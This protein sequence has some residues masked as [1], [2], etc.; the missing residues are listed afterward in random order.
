[1]VRRTRSFVAIGSSV[2]STERA[3]PR[4][5]ERARRSSLASL[6]IVACLL[7]ACGAPSRAATPRGSEHEPGI[8]EFVVSPSALETCRNGLDDNQ[9][10]LIDE[11]CSEG[12]ASVLEFVLAWPDAEVDMNLWVIDA[13]GDVVDVGNVSELGLTKQNDCP[14]ESA[15]QAQ[16]YERVFLDRNASKKFTEVRVVVEVVGRLPEGRDYPFFLGVRDGGGT[17]SFS[18][19]LRPGK[20]RV[21]REFSVDVRV[22]EPERPEPKVAA[23][24]P[25][26][27]VAED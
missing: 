16:N 27:A 2:G 1:M 6:G 10:D 4:N 24:E 12:P 14:S 15:C 26:S 19:E 3:S 20:L 18:G 5:R 23:P 13:A 21:E 25:D 8:R 9:N 22:V 11:G 7:A 17:R